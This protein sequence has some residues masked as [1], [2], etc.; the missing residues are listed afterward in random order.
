[1][2]T[3]PGGTVIFFSMA[4]S[5]GEANLATDSAGKDVRCL[6]GVGLAAEQ[7]TKMFALLRTEHVLRRHFEKLA[8][9]LGVAL[10]L[11]QKTAKL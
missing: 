1:M 5:F 9:R 10:G 8:E 11:D 7:D 6:F 4:T 3:A 2:A